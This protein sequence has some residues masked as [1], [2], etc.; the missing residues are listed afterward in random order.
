[1][2]RSADAGG[3]QR[4]YLDVHVQP[5]ARRRQVV[6][7]HGES[8]KIAVPERASDGKANRAVVKLLEETLGV[9]P[10]SVSLVSGRTS[11]RKR[12]LVEGIDQRAAW[13]R[14]ADLIIESP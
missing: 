7:M 10:G 2:A 3:P 1:M 14:L 13:R 8:L 12:L 4:F 11:R 6:G 9:G 5:G